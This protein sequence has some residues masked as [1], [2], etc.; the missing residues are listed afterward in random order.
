M[1]Q[2]LNHRNAVQQ[3]LLGR[4]GEAPVH[5]R[6]AL[7]THLFDRGRRQTRLQRG[8]YFWRAVV[9]VYGGDV[10]GP[11]QSQ[12]DRRARPLGP[13]VQLKLGRGLVAEPLPLV[14]ADPLVALELAGALFPRQNWYNRVPPIYE[15]GCSRNKVN[16]S[17][18]MTVTINCGISAYCLVAVSL[19]ICESST[20]I[21]PFMPSRALTILSKSGFVTGLI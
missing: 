9:K 15:S 16:H 20:T 5:G 8:P 7:G 21:I 1:S 17:C 13:D 18:P 2:H 4:H 14:H 12:T 19:T 11:S 6:I 3:V 10:A